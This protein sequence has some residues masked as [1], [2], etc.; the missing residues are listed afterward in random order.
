MYSAKIRGEPTTFGTSGLLY[1]SNKLM[2]DRTTNSLWS[3]FLGEPVIGPLADNGIKLSFFAVALTTWSEW[4]AEHP[5]T[6]VLSAATGIY[7]SFT[8]TPED[9]ERSLYYEYRA[10]PDTMFPVW[11][12]DPRLEAKDEVLGLTRG[13]SHKAYAVAVLQRERV[14]NDEISGVPVVIIASAKSSDARAYARDSN[15]FGLGPEGQVAQAVP[16]VLFDSDGTQW[17]VTDEALVNSGDQ[18]ETLD[19]IPTYVSFWFGW[20]AF[21][22]DTELYGGV[23]DE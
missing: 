10:R 21:H 18:T 14:V 12:R 3:S 8:Y 1:R 20:Y 5:D 16:E 15:F 9:D 2:Y 6:T 13:D 11:D 4:L 17:I 23:G 22:P 7:P 19:R